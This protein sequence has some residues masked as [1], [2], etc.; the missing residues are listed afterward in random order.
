MNPVD[1]LLLGILG[2]EINNYSFEIEN[3]SDG[4]DISIFVDNNSQSDLYQKTIELP[5]DFSISYQRI[6]GVEKFSLNYQLRD[7]TTQREEAFQDFTNRVDKILNLL[8]KSIMGGVLGYTY[9]ASNFMARREDLIGDTA[10]MF[11]VHEAI[12]THDEYETRILTDW[13]LSRKEQQYHR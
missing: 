13:M 11:D 3:S 10:K 6:A 5:Y 8:P 4:E 7:Y 1:E 9:L 2:Q 12:H